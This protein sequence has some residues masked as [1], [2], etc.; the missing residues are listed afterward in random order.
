ME[1]DESPADAPPSSNEN[2]VNM[3]DAKG[4]TDAGAENGGAESGDQSVQMETDAKVSTREFPSLIL[5][6]S[7][8]WPLSIQITDMLTVYKYL[9]Q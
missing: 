4:T 2:D 3:Q 6:S 5:H 1:T 7:F 9:L 8:L